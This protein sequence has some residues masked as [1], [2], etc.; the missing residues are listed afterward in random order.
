MI[1]ILSQTENARRD[2]IFS[3]CDDDTLDQ[4]SRFYGLSRPASY[5]VSAWRNV[6]INMVYQSRGTFRCLFHVLDALFEPW[7][8][9]SEINVT[10]DADGSFIDTT[11]TEG[12]AHRWIRVANTNEV[13]YSWL[14]YVN[15]TTNTAQLNIYKT[16]YWNAWNSA[17][18][19]T[20]S[21]LPFLIVESD[22]KIRILIDLSLLSTP[23]AYLQPAGAS[24]P[25]G[26]PLGGHLLNLLDLDPE[27]LDFGAYPLYLSGDEIGGILGDIL[28]NLIPAGVHVSVEGIQ[29]GADLG[30]PALS[31]LVE[32][33]SL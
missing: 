6:L 4:L 7:R 17:M 26:Q 32:S 30:F 19:G 16:E 3:R 14:E 18:S 28:R 33:G 10:I 27:T 13:R 8:K 5:P 24:R 22:A 25:S 11:L 20:L 1:R 21:F 31:A 9:Y 23:P 12:Y 15:E 2:T 29:Y